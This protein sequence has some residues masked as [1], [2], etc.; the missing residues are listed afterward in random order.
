M[1]ASACSFVGLVRAFGVEPMCNICPGANGGSFD[2]HTLSQKHYQAVCD[3]MD[4]QADLN[5][6]RELLWHETYVPGGQVKYNL[7][8]GEL[9]VLRDVPVHE[10]PVIHPHDLW[11]SGQWFRV[12]AP[13]VV[14]GQPGGDRSMWPNLWG[15]WIWK[16]N[17][18]DAVERVV[19]ILEQSGA[20]RIHGACSLCSDEWF[21]YP[22]LCGPKHYK[23]MME[24][25]PPN[26]PVDPDQYY[27]RWN[28]PGS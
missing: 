4:V 8:D 11:V 5:T 6:V 15:P 27:Q 10:V 20:L 7:L 12:C 16:R 26:M 9:Q 18:S 19:N 1:E 13:A 23:R 2:T 21:S 22:H 24:R 25:T 17:M 14:A 3:L 28:L